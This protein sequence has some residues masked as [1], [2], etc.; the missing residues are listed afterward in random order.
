MPADAPQ[1]MD[2]E[3]KPS[4]PNSD[5]PR[6][7]FARNSASD[8]NGAEPAATMEEY[9]EKESLPAKWS[10]GILNDRITHEVPGILSLK[11][12]SLDRN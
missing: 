2:L 3:K 8:G 4:T 12:S 10:M 1:E 5:R 11:F 6:S 7:F 9:E